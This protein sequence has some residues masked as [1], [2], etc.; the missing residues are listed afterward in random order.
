MTY[1][2]KLVS[3]FTVC[4]FIATSVYG[5]TFQKPV[6]GIKPAQ[7]DSGSDV[8]SVGEV[9][10]IAAGDNT[11]FVFGS[12]AAAETDPVYLASVAANI[13]SAHVANWETA[14]GWGDHGTEGYLTT[15][16]DPVYLASVAANITSAHVAN[17][18]T[19][20]GW[21]DHSA[22]NYF[23]HDTENSTNLSDTTDILYEEE[24]NSESE[25]ETQLVGVSNVFTN[26]DGALDD[27]D[28]SAIDVGTASPSLDDT[29]ASIEWEDA[30]D[31]D[32]AGDVADDSHAHTNS[33]LTLAST[34]LSDTSDLLYETELDIFSELQNQIAGKTLINE[35]DAIT[36]DAL[37]TASLGVTIAT[38][39]ALTFGVNRIDDGNDKLD[40]EQLADNTVD[41][42]SIDFDNVTL[43]D[44]TVDIASTDLSDTADLL[45]ETELDAFSELQTQIA[46]KTLINEEDA[47]TFD[48]LVTADAGLTIP[49]SQNLL[50]GKST[51]ST[52]GGLSQMLQFFAPNSGAASFTTGA[53][54]GTGPIL[55]FGKT[56]G[57]V[58][59]D[60]TT[61]VNDDILGQMAFFGADGTDLETMG[62][63]IVVRV[64][65][66]P[67]SNDMPTE[68]QFMTTPDDSVTSLLALTLSPTQ[69]AIFTGDIAG[70]AVE[71][72]GLF[73]VAVN[74]GVSIFSDD[75]TVVS[76][77][78]WAGIH[79]KIQIQTDTSTPIGLGLVHTANNIAGTEMQFVKS[80]GVNYGTKAII[81]D[82]AT[83]GRI[84]FIGDDGFNW[85]TL[86]A[87]ISVF[88]DGTPA[89][90]R[91]P[92]EMIFKIAEGVGDND[93]S[94]TLTLGKNKSATFVG[95]VQSGGYKSSDGTAGYTGACADGTA[96][97]VKNGL[98]TA[99]A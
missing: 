16:S 35:E 34:D 95:V 90:N 78:W 45:Y 4:M 60:Y 71:V 58:Y 10:M 63:R 83:L 56:R 66:T 89:S 51:A 33:S 39:Q 53:A 48:A 97:T 61:V 80:N 75:T 32:S 21:G 8:A 98:V 91:M 67:G 15:E 25:L 81:A 26:N 36:L 12:F 59:N 6:A 82:N 55:T 52:V 92:T 85:D 2:K 72:G 49:V 22:Q 3:V 37:L 77:A 17:W 94:T 11:E 65:G 40:G 5:S 18:E 88:I 96:L 30:N 31:L 44:F 29:D 38:N 23:D 43:A 13:T 41:D 79:P 46:G 19:A 28:V 47:V 74:D 69:D 57:T 9:V 14:Y 1:F 93:I 42:D 70:Q 86:G 87:S 99:C 73:T 50:V 54:T 62:A 24:L 76:Q 27:D 20:Y 68:I 64:D 7:L 84:S